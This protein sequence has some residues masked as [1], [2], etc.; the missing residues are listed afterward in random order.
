MLDCDTI[1]CIGGVY[2]IIWDG[3]KNDIT[4]FSTDKYLKINSCGFQNVKQG[5]LVTRKKGRVDYHILLV[6]GGEYN[7]LYRGKTYSLFSG[8]LII[9]E[10]HEE[11]RYENKPGSSSMWCHFT[12]TAADEIMADFDLTG[13]VY[14]TESDKELC[15]VFSRMIQRHFLP[16][17]KKIAI[18]AL[19]ELVYR[20]STLVNNPVQ[21]KNSNIILPALTYININYNKKIT[22]DELASVAGYSKSRFSHVFSECTGTTPVKYQNDVRL[23]MSREMLLSTAQSIGEIAL[24]C[25][26]ED[27]LYFSRLFKKN[28]GITPTEYRTQN[29][30]A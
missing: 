14:F 4:N 6:T 11:Q 1:I 27:Q 24:N 2:M 7:V 26:F 19:I 29:K 5:Q 18:S 12:G 13:G 30:N 3:N 23:K 22:L 15:D 21:K 8:N 16:E 10:P 20:I 28:F 17:Q 9:Y 25:G